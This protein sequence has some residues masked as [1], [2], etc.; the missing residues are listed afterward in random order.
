M[1]QIGPRVCQMAI[2]R[3]PRLHR[4]SG[5]PARLLLALLFMLTACTTEPTRPDLTAPTGGEGRTTLL[6]SD[7]LLRTVPEQ[8][9]GP[10]PMANVCSGACPADS[11]IIDFEG[12]GPPG[13]ALQL[14][15]QY[16]DV[17]F[18]NGVVLQVPG[19]NYDQYPPRSGVAVATAD[20][21]ETG[22]GSGILH[23]SLDYEAMR[24]RGYVTS[25]SP[26][27]LRCF[28]A[29]G[30]AI[31]ETVFAGGNL[32]VLHG[33]PANQPAEVTAPGIR[34]CQFVGPDN[35]YSVDDLTVVW[36]E[37]EAPLLT[38]DSKFR[39]E[40]AECRVTGVSAVLGWHFE[41]ILGARLLGQDSVVNVSRASSDTV[42]SGIGVLS[43]TVSV[44]V[45]VAGTVDT[46][47]ANWTVL[48][49]TGPA[50]RWSEVDWAFQEDGP[51]ICGYSDFTL[52]FGGPFPGGLAVNRRGSDCISGG[53][54][55]PNLNSAPEAG[56]AVASVPSGPNEGLWYLTQATFHIDRVSEMNPFVRPGGPAHPLPNGP[57]FN[58]CK[59]A[60]GLQ[61]NP[62]ISVSFHMFNTVCKSFD[63][64]PMYA[65]I[66]A[67]EGFG[68]QNPLDS[69][70]ANGHEARRRIAARDLAND[71]NA[72][73]EGFISPL[74]P[75]TLRDLVRDSVLTVDARISAFAGDATGLVKDNYLDPAGGCGKAYVFRT[76]PNPQRYVFLTLTQFVAG[77]TL[78]P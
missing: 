34:S 36:G 25:F 59:A 54:I 1:V 3:S 68:T 26:L 49:R 35:Q 70:T 41:G 78:C 13:T 71:P 63:L 44:H 65:G 6:S 29:G 12:L 8:A 67:H 24:V 51:T 77:A 37:E 56:T 19:Y 16:P 5:P 10:I 45:L 58:A 53:S 22:D 61:G 50:W 76:S 62:A 47:T 11:V 66:W 15:S 2:R 64:T 42:W 60:L 30:T 17:T 31:A 75:S 14:T 55:E 74:S 57:D 43:G 32:A 7:A 9:A 46:L 38:C 69:A 18:A 72:L 4:G 33:G 73:I 48:P 21:F 52:P 20:P 27:T 28:D 40:N 39:G 23:L